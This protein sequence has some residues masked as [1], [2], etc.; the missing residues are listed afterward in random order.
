MTLSINCKDAG[1][2]TCSQ[3]ISEETEQ[4]LF[5]NANMLWKSME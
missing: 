1:D 3:S 2:P 5:D 4:E